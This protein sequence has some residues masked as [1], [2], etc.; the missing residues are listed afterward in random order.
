MVDTLAR[1]RAAVRSITVTFAKSPQRWI[2]SAITVRFY[3]LAVPAKTPG[4][5]HRP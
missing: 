1:Q 5:L 4:S 2:L 3:Q